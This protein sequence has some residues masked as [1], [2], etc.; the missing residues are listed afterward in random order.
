MYLT[1]NGWNQTRCAFVAP[2]DG[3]Y[4][5]SYSA[6]L[7]DSIAAEIGLHKTRPGYSR[8]EKFLGLHWSDESTHGIFKK[9]NGKD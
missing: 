4:V 6:E 7:A 9:P 5:F 1:G 2:K 3:V 8:N